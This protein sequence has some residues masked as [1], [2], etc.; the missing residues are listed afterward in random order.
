MAGF[1][2]LYTA[3]V[4]PPLPPPSPGWPVSR[5]PSIFAHSHPQEF[6]EEFPAA[7]GDVVRPTLWGEEGVGGLG[8][9]PADTVSVIWERG[10]CVECSAG[11]LF[12]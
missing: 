6:R 2:L 4:A 9:I 1:S 8:E 12:I 10:M 7:L 5:E 3:A 11:S